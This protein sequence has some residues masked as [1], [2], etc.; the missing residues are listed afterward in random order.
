MSVLISIFT[1]TFNRQRYLDVTG[2]ITLSQT[3]RYKVLTFLLPLVI[4]FVPT[5]ATSQS[6]IPDG[7]TKTDVTSQGN[8]LDITGGNLSQDGSNLFHSFSQF[9]LTSNQTAS[10]LSNPSIKNILSRITSGNPSVINGLIQV[11]GGNSNLFL[12]NPAGI[13]FGSNA[14]L[15]VPSSFTATTATSIGIGSDWFKATGNNNYAQ[16]NGTPSTFAFGVN[17][18]L[19]TITNQGKLVVGEGQNLTFL[20]GSVI[21]SGNLTAAGGN[22]IIAA[23]S[24]GN[25]LRLSQPGHLLSLEI[26][27]IQGQDS[28]LINNISTSSL[29]QLLT[30]SS[31]AGEVSVSGTVDVASP[32]LGGNV[33][34]FGNKVDLLD[35][36]INASGNNGGGL[37]LIGGDFQGQGTV[38]RAFSTNVTQNSIITAD[39]NINGKGGRVIIWAD[40]ATHFL[41]KI[42]TRGGTAGGDGGFVEVSGKNFLDYRGQV[43]AL[44]PFGKVGTLLLDPTNIEVVA[45]ANANTLDLNDVN[46]AAAPDLPGGTRLS[47][48]VL[49]N[50]AANIILQASNDLI[51]SVPVNIT[52]QG[53]GLAAD[54][55]NNI[56]ANQSITTNGGD[57]TLT[58][59]R[60]IL[61][62]TITT[63][64]SP[65]GDPPLN[66]SGAVNLIA[67][68]N[69]TTGTID[70]SFTSFDSNG[71]QG[72]AVTLNAVGNLTTGIIN[73]FSNNFAQASRGNTTSSG[74]LVNLAGRNISFDSINNSGAANVVGMSGVGGDVQIVARG[75][76]QGTGTVINPT[77]TPNP[78]PIPL[79][80]VPPNTTIFSRG[81]TQGGVITIQHNG[82][83][84][85]DAFAVGDLSSGNGLAGAIDT[86]SGIVSTGVFPVLANNGTATGTPNG[87]SINSVN[88]PPR[89]TATP[90]L[91]DV[92]QGQPLTFTF[93]D[94]QVLVNDLNSDR[95][96][97]NT[98]VFIDTVTVGALT[99]N[100]LPVVGNNITISPGDVLVYTP[101]RDIIGQ[102]SAFTI[103]A[104]DRVSVSPPTAITLNVIQTPTPLTPTPLP[105][106]TP[107]P[108][109]TPIPKNPLPE[110]PKLPRFDITG[111]LPSL[112]IDLIVG[113]IEYNFTQQFQQ[114]LG[115]SSPTPLKSLDEGREILNQV[116]KATGI[117]PA[118]IY[119]A[120]LPQTITSS[121]TTQQQDSDQLELVVV[122]AK[123]SPIRKRLQATREQVLKVAQEYRKQVT[124][125]RSKGYLATSQQLYQWLIAPLEG[126]LQA[127]EIQNLVFIMD[128]GLRSLPVAALHDGKNFLIE[129]YSVGLM[130]SLSLADT[131]YKDIKDAKILAMGSATFA[132]QKPLPAVPTEIQTVS[133]RLWQGKS[134]LNDA[135]T[136][137]N[138]KQARQQQPFGIIHLATHG[139]FKSGTPAN[140]YIQLW[141]SK[142]RLDQLRQLGWNNPPV[143]L[144]VLSACRTALGD[145]QAELG[146]AG[147][148]I[149]AGV[150]SALASLWYVS[151]QGTLALMTDFYIQLKDAPI[152]SEALRQSQLAMIKGQVLIKDGKLITPKTEISLPSEL[153]LQ[154]QTLQHPYYWAA[155]TMIG[156][157]W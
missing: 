19:G 34:I 154:N 64:S 23:V 106:P 134:F 139:E 153:A 148:G 57:V 73:A 94:L 87:I 117:K 18:P 126:D 145:E 103:R 140:S 65:L 4:N 149:L 69:I 88:T 20:G 45:A 89:L 52:N 56:T 113:Q 63:S 129:R 96:R 92:Q 97:D 5:V 50:A 31:Q 13:I 42:S 83:S 75:V 147:L 121:T 46:N 81:T 54:A 152:K 62:N 47:V 112:K 130:P 78:T 114:Y 93:A 36:K 14:R 39:S 15:D 110:Q 124:D 2:N 10:F 6:I 3:Q 143:E 120:F 156:N 133:Q 141:D 91:A 132:D 138:L 49:N 77:T 142:L 104:S 38:P 21:N 41:G 48:D 70:T 72:G 101:P 71:S 37:V 44:A 32:Q 111:E 118:L 84:N 12:L 1:T 100:G 29:P 7:S 125:V 27:P 82:G 9:G 33:Q 137:E 90:Q 85:N 116:E 157:P 135:F 25:Y 131:R 144:L 107:S 51:F 150:K 74:G 55:G 136:L 28:S 105:S 99:R 109:P 76:I 11:A 108:T 66:R 59:G 53:V 128:S 58:A 17:Q 123:G 22:I 68:G 61:A 127:R 8:R 102:I 24:E 43:D 115:Q 35:A 146:F 80:N 40:D 67:G 86:N 155:F 98:T 79:L 30:G 122:T 95:S 26:Q 119:V 151:D 16:L 60:N